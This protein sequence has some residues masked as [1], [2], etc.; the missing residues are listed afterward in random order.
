MWSVK[1]TW[2]QLDRILKLILLMMEF[3]TCLVSKF[4]LTYQK[5]I[6]HGGRKDITGGYSVDVTIKALGR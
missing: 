2:K 1:A 6:V 5:E 4:N 3:L